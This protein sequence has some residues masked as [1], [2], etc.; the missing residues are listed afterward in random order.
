MSTND[1]SGFPS[2][3]FADRFDVLEVFQGGEGQTALLRNQADGSL[4]IAKVLDADAPPAEA[5][6]LL[7]LRHARIPALDEVGRTDDG[8]VFLLR[9]YVEGH[10]LDGPGGTTTEQ[11]L[12]IARQ[13]LEVLAYV[14]LR[15]ILHLD[16]K[17]ANILLDE[18]SRIHLLD[19]GL[20]VRS[21]D[22]SAGGTW[23]FAAPEILLGS[24]VDARSDLFSLGAVLVFLL[25]PQ[26][27]PPP[28]AR[29]L[30]MFPSKTFFEAAGVRPE[31]FPAPLREFLNRCLARRPQR[32]FADA[33][34]A[35][36][37]LV[38]RAGRPSRTLLHPDPVSIF[39]AEL[40]AAAREA[41]RADVQ[42]EGGT[43]SERQQLALHAL[44]SRADVH[45]Y[46]ENDDS[47]L[48]RRA[49]GPPL[50][51]RL[52][53]MNQTRL[54]PFL[55][56]VLG[57]PE[58]MAK[59]AANYLLEQTSPDTDAIGREL[60]RFCDA[61]IIVPDGARWSW[62]EAA[63]GRLLSPRPVQAAEPTA[64]SLRELAAAGHGNLATQQFAA[65][66]ATL[67]ADAEVALR[68]GLVQGL[69][70]AGEPARAL[71]LSTDLPIERAQGLLDLGQ[72]TDAE[73]VL[74]TA[75]AQ[76]PADEGDAYTLLL[77]RARLNKEQGEAAIALETL[78]RI[79][80]EE[81]T[82]TILQNRAALL[83]TLGRGEEARAILQELAPSLSAE[84]TPYLLAATLTSLGHA[85]RRL[86]NLELAHDNFH[87]A[88][89]LLLRMGH[90][91]HAATAAANL[92]VVAK[93]LNRPEEAVDNLRQARGLFLHIGDRAGAAIAE[94]NLGNVALSINDHVS[95]ARRLEPAVQTLRELGAHG[96]AAHA[97]VLWAQALAALGRSEQSEALIDGLD[98]ATRTRLQKEVERV[99]SMLHDAQPSGLP[100]GSDQPTAADG[101]RR[102]TSESNP[103]P[104]QETSTSVPESTGPSR[105]LFRTFLAVNRRLAHESDLGKAMSTLLDSAIT[106][107]GGR[108]GYL[109]VMR[110]DGLQR[111]FQTGEPAPGGQAFSR[112]L[113][114]RA[115][116]LQRTLTGE[117]ALADRELQEMPSI[118]NLQIRSAICA[119][120]RSATGA[121]GAIYVE[122][123]GRAGAFSESD[124]ESLEVLADQAAIA[125]DRM[126]REEQLTEEL[127]N[128][129]RE[130]AVVQRTARRD[131]VTM[132]GRSQP[133]K[134]LKAQIDKI[135][136]LDLSVLIL[137][138]TGTGK[139][140]V[141]RAIHN[142]SQSARGPFVAENCSALPPELMERELFGH[143]A[144]SF[145]GADRDRPGLLELASGGTLF[146]DEVGDMPP[147]LQVKLLRALQEKRIRRIG[148]SE[149]LDVDVRILAATHKDLR[150]MVARGD[151]REDLFFRL[152]AVEV[153]VPPLRDRHG[154]VKILAEHFLERLCKQ[155]GVSR[156]FSA[157]AMAQ[158]QAYPWPGNV[159]ELEHVVARA[160]LLAD[161][162]EI[163]DTQLP[164]VDAA[165]RTAVDEIG[166]ATT[167]AT[168]GELTEA[169]WPAIPLAEA[170][171]RTI[172][173]AL[174][175]CGGE[176]SAAARLLGI[177]RTALYE[178]LKRI[179]AANEDQ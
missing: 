57:L 152:A 108:Q 179:Q 58:D 173:A 54:W 38:G 133:V 144:G 168:A 93:D 44:G 52:P 69:L 17:P 41:G 25:W 10:P 143:V 7:S 37:F 147:A 74:A 40:D 117:D 103:A 170:E 114:N 99:R 8:R 77:L 60:N 153:Q 151:F 149:T 50:P 19:F 31:D 12:S 45:G 56:D 47:T 51:W 156:R 21:G 139:E 66:V 128:S 79:P 2:R 165:A 94:A 34:E 148:G 63:Q 124:K 127:E 90:A 64:A 122:H 137:G 100:D 135:A 120:F 27:S 162:E 6:V 159:R 43:R 112:S 4:H 85:E 125:V 22:R 68:R 177:S 166:G 105:E 172:L 97:T 65:T 95:A 36:E 76:T 150:A 158:L 145:T 14:H 78:A 98:E 71:P 80:A 61:G 42:I 175:H 115:M 39:G 167:T 24:P 89:G 161:D 92:G 155:H 178:K 154:D 169:T 102:P 15:G 13:T 164:G 121:D 116:Q 88:R 118:R 163:A 29:F 11:A 81:T 9:Q 35:L 138:E 70:M 75:D 107:T 123:A 28:L 26:Q 126:L 130:L 157:S 46:D 3:Q 106:L 73:G 72:V 1:E 87:R 23:F 134:N 53:T 104:S 176:K 86:G 146:L 59:S 109:L 171:R 55:H 5:S 110:P 113:A 48:L 49:G 132:I 101:T 136:P 131:Q 91:R 33:Q 18:A 62:P 141:A 111:E 96:A 16:L 119:P 83:E 174:E 160:F 30:R 84:Q 67:D 82:P 140:L 32:R 129:R 20:A 142:G